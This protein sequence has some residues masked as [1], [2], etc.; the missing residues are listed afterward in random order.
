LVRLAADLIERSRAEEQLRESEERLRFAQDTANIGTFDWNIATGQNTWTPKLETMYGLRPGGFLGTQPAWEALVHPE[1]RPRVLQRVRESLETG[2]PMEDEWRVIWPDG[3]VHWLAGRWRMLKNAGGE[4]VRV[5]GVNIDVT[6]RKHMEEELR[7]SEE[8]FRLATKATNDAIYDI[9]LKTGTVGWNDTYSALYG[10]PPETSDSWQWW[11]DRIH[12]EDRE[13]TVADLRAAIASG[14]FSWACEYR[15]R[16]VDGE[17]SHIY[18]RAYLARNASGKAWRVIGAMQDLTDRKKTEAALAESEERFRNM[19]DTAPVMIWMTRPDNRGTF[20]NKFCL[21]FTGHTLDLGRG[22]GWIAGLHPED[23]EQLLR[24]IDAQRQFRSLVRIRRADGEYRWVLLTGI[25]RFGPD[26]VFGGY[27]GS[28]ID[29]TDQKLIEERLRASEARLM[30]AQR[31]AKLG[32]WERDATTGNTEFSEEMLRILG[33]P[34][35]PPRSLAEFLNYVHPEDRERVWKGALRARSSSETGA[36]EYRIVRADSE[37]R[38]VRSVLKAIRNECGSVIRVVGATQDITDFKRAQEE[39]FARQKL[40]SVG[41]LAGGIAHDF[42]NLLGGVNAQAEL[43]LAELDAGSACREELK[44]I[45]E[46]AMRGSEIVRQLMIYAGKESEVAGR[47]DLSKIV[48]QMLALLK[49]SVSKHA[50]IIAD[51]AQNLPAIAAS[52]AQLRQIVMNLITNASDAIGDR[53]GVIRVTTKPVTVAG[54]SAAVE[55]L[56]PEGDYLTLEVSDTGT[57]M[58]PETQSRVFDPF[59]TTKSAGH[60]LGLAVVSGIVRSLGGAI[61]L[62]SE[63]GKGSTFQILL[64]CA[65]TTGTAMIYPV[66][67]IEESAGPCRGAVVL[68]VEDEDPLR[69]AVVKM[70]HK[71]GFEVL[72]AASGSVA[73]NLLRENRG[74]IDMVLLDMTIPGATSHEVVA[75]AAQ[76]KPDVRVVLTSAYSEETLRP[77]MSA[78]AI[79]GFIRKPFQFTDLE[80]IL[81]NALLT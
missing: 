67:T 61:R 23:R 40:E 29:I 13:R 1:D 68:V 11:I 71:R 73:I 51:L 6:D 33:M 37:V 21:E 50:V 81:Q 65:D 44:A 39:S 56:L 19:A 26:D 60:G 41:T 20:F 7:K 9:D 3:S 53:D 66:S 31:L 74:K 43:A 42:N 16:R 49:V 46:V 30:T 35:H 38:F 12:P 59:Y 63:L 52:P 47:V 18:D 54:E 55:E 70:L 25:P 58:S 62:T 22:D 78:S 28:G 72:E 79:R 2:A 32:S 76:S 34:D 36:G 80:Q 69:H 8:R 10:R 27:I 48:D 4:P 77:A 14:A 15:F 57:G 45:R 17:W 75:E 64:P 5:T 24:V